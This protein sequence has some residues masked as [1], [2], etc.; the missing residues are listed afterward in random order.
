[1]I[2]DSH[3]LQVLYKDERMVA[4]YKPNNLLVHR[5]G[6]DRDR[7]A[8][9]QLVRDQLAGQWV[10]PVHRLDRATAG[11]LLFA[12]D[13]DAAGK[14][15]AAFREQR[16]V[17]RYRAVVR[18]WIEQGGRVDKPLGR[19]RRGEGGDPQPAVTEFKPLAWAELPT[20]VSRYST[21]R[22][23]CIDLWPR[24]GRRHQLR[25]HLKSLSHPI[26]GDTTHGD[27]A[28]NSLFRELFGV[29]R[30]MLMATEICLPH[31]EDAQPIRITAQPDKEW[32]YVLRQ[33]GIAC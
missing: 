26:I 10:Y 3:R 18:G 23:T 7:V 16:V 5:T 9:V 22:Y 28:H 25:R 12:L 30:L 1:M 2:T 15:A 21:A 33:L 13:P 6:I 19:G 14:I 8:A 11:V 4:V 29:W 20:P 24:S 17:K 31:P 27:S 32:Q